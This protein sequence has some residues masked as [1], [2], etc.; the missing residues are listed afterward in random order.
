NGRLFARGS[1]DDKA[2][3]V[4]FVAAVASWL[5]SSGELPCNIKLFIEGEEEIGSPNLHKFLEKYGE[6]LRADCVVLADS[7]NF[8]TGIPALTYRLRGMCSVDVEVRCLERPLHS[9]RGAGVVPD[10]VAILC[11]LLSSL[12]LDESDVATLSDEERNALAALPFDA[13]RLRRDAAMLDGVRLL[14]NEALPEH[15][16][17][18]PAITIT[19]LEARPVKGAVNQIIDSARARISIRTVPNM[20][21]RAT[22]ETI[23]KQ[24]TNEPPSHAHVT[25]RI[26]AHAPWWRTDAIGP[27]FDA[28]RRALARGYG[29]EP[30]MQGTGGTI[31][32]VR[33]FADAFDNLPLILLGVEDPPC[34]AHSEDESLSLDDW[35]KC[36]KSAIY[37]FEE[38]PGD[39]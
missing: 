37:L 5:A 11:K 25:A 13:N 8:D 22:G 28:A 32:F 14:I 3:I 36:A 6:Q 20:D 31:A 39:R 15:L 23:V 33:T 12:R 30:V 29:L 27:A 9:G 34:N 24:L 16:W 1:S 19:A 21:S 35:E 18:R 7:P 38:V 4:A 26:V 2:G 10:A 17:T